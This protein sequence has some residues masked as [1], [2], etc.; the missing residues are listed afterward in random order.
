MNASR[1]R[2]TQ[3]YEGEQIPLCAYWH[4]HFGRSLL[5]V[6]K[7]QCE[8]NQLLW[9]RGGKKEEEKRN[10]VRTPLEMPH[11]SN[12]SLKWRALEKTLQ[13][14]NKL[15]SDSQLHF[16]TLDK[17]RVVTRVSVAARL[18]LLSLLATFLTW[19][20]MSQEK[21]NSPVGSTFSHIPLKRTCR[22]SKTDNYQPLLHTM[23][24]S[25]EHQYSCFPQMLA[26]GRRD[27]RRS[28]TAPC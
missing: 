7:R 10:T 24:T 28:K 13:A 1:Q 15:G 6:K 26:C 17:V 18:F 8:W 5:P 27:F 16:G 25:E 21:P 2:F 4:A 23:L 3:S 19:S 9:N 20:K 14:W 11:K 12:A 22:A